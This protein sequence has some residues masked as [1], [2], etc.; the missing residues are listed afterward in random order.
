ML[1]KLSM[2]ANVSKCLLVV[3]NISDLPACLSAD[4]A[5]GGMFAGTFG[6]VPHY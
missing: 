1:N 6:N 5:A 2:V 3:A 4:M